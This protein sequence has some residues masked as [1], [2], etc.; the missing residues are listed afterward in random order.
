MDVEGIILSA[1]GQTKKDKYFRISLIHGILT[2]TKLIHTK[3]RLV[4][5][6]SGVCRFGEMGEGGQKLQ[7]SIISPGDVMYNNIVTT[8]NSSLLCI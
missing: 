1:I 4:V 3:N 7:T 6:K 8:V 2:K 5:A